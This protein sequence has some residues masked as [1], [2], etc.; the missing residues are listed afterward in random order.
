MVFSGLGGSV[1]KSKRLNGEEVV[2]VAL[3]IRTVNPNVACTLASHAYTIFR[4]QWS[5]YV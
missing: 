2:V 5:D 4:E 1:G 3:S